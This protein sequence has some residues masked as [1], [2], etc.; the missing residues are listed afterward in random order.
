MERLPNLDVGS[1]HLDELFPPLLGGLV[2]TRADAFA[3]GDRHARDQGENHEG[4]HL[5]TEDARVVKAGRSTV[6]VEVCNP[7]IVMSNQCVE[8][9][10][11]GPREEERQ[12]SRMEAKPHRTLGIC[13]TE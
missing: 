9:V 2:C 12:H 11:S 7:T 6:T 5:S 4:P 1:G 13:S 8:P 3:E 10:P